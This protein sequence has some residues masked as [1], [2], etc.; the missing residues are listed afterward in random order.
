MSIIRVAVIAITL[1]L[2]ACTTAPQIA[3]ASGDQIDTAYVNA[4]NHIAQQRGLQIV[5]MRYPTKAE[6]SA[7]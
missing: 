4:V 5:W 7:R 2:A 1:G 6:S 3:A